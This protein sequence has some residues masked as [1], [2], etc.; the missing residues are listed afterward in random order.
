ME[1]QQ[2]LIQMVAVWSSQ[3]EMGMEKFLDAYVPAR[4]RVATLFL[5]LL[6]ALW[7]AAA[8]VNWLFHNEQEQDV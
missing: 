8:M 2:G 4:Y 5:L 6:V 7:L 3:G 1:R